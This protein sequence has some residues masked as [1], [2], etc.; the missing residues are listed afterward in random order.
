MIWSTW[1][2]VTA[3]QAIIEASARTFVFRCVSS[4]LTVTRESDG[5]VWSHMQTRVWCQTWSQPAQSADHQQPAAA[6]HLGRVMRVT[7]ARRILRLLAAHRC[8]VRPAA[9]ARQLAYKMS[10]VERV[11]R[12]IAPI[13]KFSVAGS[14]AG[15]RAQRRYR[16]RERRPSARPSQHPAAPW[17]AESGHS[18]HQACAVFIVIRVHRGL[19]FVYSRYFEYGYNREWTRVLSGPMRAIECW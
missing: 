10:T 5:Y 17:R 12:V 7:T 6:R 8:A 3:Q 2:L 14:R 4:H 19:N 15:R 9:L 11:W 1:C 16:A 18:F 13:G